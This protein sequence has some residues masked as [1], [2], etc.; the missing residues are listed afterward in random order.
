MGK[1]KMIYGREAP[2]KHAWLPRAG[3][4]SRMTFFSEDSRCYF[5]NVA[6]GLLLFYVLSNRLAWL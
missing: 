2:R 3:R 1:L 6:Y 4:A 5:C